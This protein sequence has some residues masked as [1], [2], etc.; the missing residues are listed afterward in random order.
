MAQL[1]TVQC[2]LAVV[3]IKNWPLYQLDINNA[4]RHRDLN[5]E[6]YMTPPPSYHIP[7]KNLI[8]RLHKSLCGLRQ[9]SHQWFENFSTTLKVTGFKQSIADYSLFTITNK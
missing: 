4:F 1:V 3:S 6:A 9:A 2:L 5:E 8:C 7:I